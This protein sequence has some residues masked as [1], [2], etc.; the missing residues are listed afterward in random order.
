MIIR[1][2]PDIEQALVECARRQGTTPELIALHSL[3]ER[4]MPAVGDEIPTEGTKTLAEFLGGHIG[5]LHSSDHV[6]GG[7]RMSEDGGKRFTAGMLSKRQR[8]KS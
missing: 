1:I 5:I 8:G 7:A 4:F 3:R 6:P 2:P